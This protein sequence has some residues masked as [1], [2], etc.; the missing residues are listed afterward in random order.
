MYADFLKDS[1]RFRRA[2]RRV[3][4]SWPTSCEQFLSN[5]SINR[6]AWM[7]QASMCIETGTPATFR[8]GFKLLTLKQQQRANAIAQ[9]AI[10]L[11]E[12]NIY[13]QM[14]LPL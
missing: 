13:P 8:A 4:A 2:T 7:G 3:I 9:E 10:E 12:K 14:R 5:S 11:W 6:I 1:P